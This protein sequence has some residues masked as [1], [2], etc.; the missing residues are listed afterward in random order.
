MEEL[1]PIA[2]SETT[3]LMSSDNIKKS[4][5]PYRVDNYR[6]YRISHN[7]VDWW[8]ESAV[9]IGTYNSVPYIASIGFYVQKSD[10]KAEIAWLNQPSSS[11]LKFYKKENALYVLFNYP[12]EA[13][14]NVLIAST[15]GIELISVGIAEPDSSYIPII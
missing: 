14:T 12:Q 8:R 6:F 3:G 13:P 7:A 9:I 10:P 11:M 15:S 2:D 1:M 5:S 4:L